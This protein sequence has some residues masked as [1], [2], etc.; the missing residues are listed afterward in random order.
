MKTMMDE[1]F[2]LNTFME[3]TIGCQSDLAVEVERMKA[4]LSRVGEE[5][6]AR[7]QFQTSDMASAVETEWTEKD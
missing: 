5:F 6:S 4:E 3:E 7:C 1:I 2:V